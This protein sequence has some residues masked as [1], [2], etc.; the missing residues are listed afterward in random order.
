MA[1][2]QNHGEVGEKLMQFLENFNRVIAAVDQQHEERLRIARSL[3]DM[4]SDDRL[5]AE[6]TGL[7]VEE[8]QQLRQTGGSRKLQ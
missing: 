4:I 2:D 7:R 5:L 3:L 6:K 1:D 8:V